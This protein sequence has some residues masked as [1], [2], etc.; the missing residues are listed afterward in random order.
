MAGRNRAPAAPKPA[1]RV[2]IKSSWQVGACDRHGRVA[3]ESAPAPQRVASRKRKGSTPARRVRTARPHGERC[4][5][6]VQ[7]ARSGLLLRLLR[8]LP[9]FVLAELPDI[10]LCYSRICRLHLLH[11][12]LHQRLHVGAVATSTLIGTRRVRALL[13][14]SGAW[15]GL[16]SCRWGRCLRECSR[17]GYECSQSQCCSSHWTP[18][19]TGS[20]G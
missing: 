1:Y 5:S 12:V 13:L 6:A 4:A 14:W 7:E 20:R 3:P 8:R 17:R 10:A 2:S 18:P 16:R 9:D 11:A 19:C 15:C